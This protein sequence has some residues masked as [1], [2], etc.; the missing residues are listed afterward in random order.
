MLCEVDVACK[1]SPKRRIKKLGWRR[2]RVVDVS[3]YVSGAVCSV[4]N[5]R[6]TN[7]AINTIQGEIRVDISSIGVV[8]IQAA[9]FP[10][11]ISDLTQVWI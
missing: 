6:S 5:D 8:G 7:D 10:T 9:K 11:K 4:N 2:H 1:H 3:T